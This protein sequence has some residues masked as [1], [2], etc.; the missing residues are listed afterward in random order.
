MTNL[1][2][3]PDACPPGIFDAWADDYDREAGAETG[4]L[5]TGYTRVSESV[6]AWS[7]PFPGARLLDL[8]T[9]TGIYCI[10]SSA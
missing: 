5:F 9:G 4:F 2:P 3:S 7:N 10:R 8:G 1:I 6:I